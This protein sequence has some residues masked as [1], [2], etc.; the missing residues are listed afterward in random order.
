MSGLPGGRER[1][2]LSRRWHAVLV[3]FGLVDSPQTVEQADRV[4]ALE[5]E[6]ADLRRRLEA[7]ERR[8]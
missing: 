4:A 5:A 3:Y 7:L 2:T 8:G 6:V 1:P